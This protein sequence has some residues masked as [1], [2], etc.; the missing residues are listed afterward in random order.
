MS[1][2]ENADKGAENKDMEN[3][4][5]DKDA[6]E[7]KAD[8]K[9]GLMGGLGGGMGKMGG[10]FGADDDTGS[11]NTVDRKPV[12]SSCCC[13]LCN[14]SNENTDNV[15][16]CGCFPIKCGVMTIG[17]L[18]WLFT[19]YMFCCTFFLIMNEYIRWWFPFVT[20][21]LM[22]PNVIGVCFFIG[23]FTKDCKRT[24][25]NLKSAM[26]LSII[27]WSLC[28]CWQCAY[29]LWMYKNE[30]VYQG[31]GDNL[32]SYRAMSKKSYIFWLLAEASF[33]ITIL[34]YFLCVIAKY[35][36]CFK[37][38]EEDEAKDDK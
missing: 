15:T 32:E 12:R 30:N 19:V 8:E 1:D 26:I 25:G 16:C 5:P 23:W 29:Y 33:S 9:T 27:S 20:L 38:E 28:I 36:N 34:A 17:V 13:C 31:Y 2:K 24:R 10:M 14:C 37:E 6:D 7:N 21:I 18:L 3:G 22:A 11:D 35:V 4:K